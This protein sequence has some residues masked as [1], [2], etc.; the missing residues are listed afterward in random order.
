MSE[1]LKNENSESATKVVEKRVT[2][3][4]IRRR[5]KKV[6]EP[7]VPVQPAQEESAVESAT[8]QVL[9]PEAAP[10]ETAEKQPAAEPKPEQIV[11]EATPQEIPSEKAEPRDEGGESVAAD[12]GLKLKAPSEAEKKIGVVGHIVLERPAPTPQQTTVAA[13]GTVEIISLKEDWRDKF[14]RTRRKKS[15]DELEMEAIQRA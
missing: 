8:Q 3:T 10:Q 13:D 6:V 9:Q 5:A 15:R 2:T 7:E 11:Q 4:I 1:E 12:E 14:K